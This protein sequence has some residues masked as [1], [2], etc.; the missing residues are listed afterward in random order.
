M[1]P[2]L[3]LRHQMKESHGFINRKYSLHLLFATFVKVKPL[4]RIEKS[5]RGVWL[6]L[7]C[8]VAVKGGGAVVCTSSVCCSLSV[9]GVLVTTILGEQHTH[10]TSVSSSLMSVNYL[11]GFE[12]KDFS[13]AEVHCC[14]KRLVSEVHGSAGVKEIY[15]TLIPL[16]CMEAGMWCSVK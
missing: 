15:I 2:C 4:P 7:W 11:K 13:R 3:R 8:L 10:W 12:G 1:S 16:A 9:H 6:C 5:G 14:I